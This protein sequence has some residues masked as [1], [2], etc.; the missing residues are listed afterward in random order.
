MDHSGVFS[1]LKYLNLYLLL[2]LMAASLMAW[3]S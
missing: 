2:V 3:V 1:G